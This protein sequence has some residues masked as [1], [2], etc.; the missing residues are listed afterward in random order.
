VTG[1][2]ACVGIC[3]AGRQRPVTRA[4]SHVKQL[5]SGSGFD[6]VL[7]LALVL[8]THLGPANN[9]Q[10]G[11]AR[12]GPRLPRGWVW[13]RPG[14]S[15]GGLH[16]VQVGQLADQPPVEAGDELAWV[17]VAAERQSVLKVPCQSRTGRRC[18]SRKIHGSWRKTATPWLTRNRRSRRWSVRPACDRPSIDSHSRSSHDEEMETRSREWR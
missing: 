1:G 8:R 11:G 4:A 6:V 9:T 15:I 18:R 10:D 7:T 3:T 12:C 13:R 16:G 17:R 2:T 5:A 14:R